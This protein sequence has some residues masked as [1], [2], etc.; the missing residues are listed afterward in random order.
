ME[1][2]WFR[3]GKG[4][5]EGHMGN[6]VEGQEGDLDPTKSGGI[7][8]DSLD[9]SFQCNKNKANQR[10]TF[11]KEKACNIKANFTLPCLGQSLLCR[12]TWTTS[13]LL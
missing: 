3:E 11:N 7:T 8:L 10:S 6:K 4:R 5:S 2:Q 13:T 1:T 9:Q 12:H